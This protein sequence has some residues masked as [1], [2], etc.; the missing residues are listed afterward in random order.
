MH[1]RVTRNLCTCQH[2][3]PKSPAAMQFFAVSAR[4]RSAFLLKSQLIVIVQ[5]DTL[6]A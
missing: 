5:I 2:I 6:P 3:T 1:S 4:P